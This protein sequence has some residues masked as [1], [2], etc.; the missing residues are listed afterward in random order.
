MMGNAVL[1]VSGLAGITLY[2]PEELILTA[3][4]GTPLREINETIAR[5]GQ[6]LAF[7]PPDFG[8]LWNLPMDRGTI[9]GCLAV[10]WGGSRRPH[11]GS[12][13]DHFLG[14]EAVN[15]LGKQYAAGGRVVKN[16]TGFDLPKLLAGSFGT[17][18][19]LTEVTIK[20]LP[21]PQSTL[22]LA[23][24]DL[25]DRTAVGLLSDMLATPAQISGA[26]HLPHAVVKLSRVDEIASSGTALTLVRLE[27]IDVSVAARAQALQE[28]VRKRQ[29]SAWRLDTVAS[30]A[31]WREITNAH[32]FSADR[33]Q[34][35]WRLSVPPSSGPALMQAIA[36][37][38]AS[39]GFFDWAGGLLWISV[40]PSPDAYAGTIRAALRSVAGLDGHATLVRAPDAV[41]E[42]VSPFE[43]LT[44][45]LMTLTRRVKDQF[46]PMHVLNRARKYP[47]F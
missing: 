42:S 2:E 21:S 15:G 34:A 12:A 39:T 38:E 30:L 25:D 1:D 13:R 6:Q 10:G 14:L 33:Q 8:A 45:E 18:G 24:P 5:A 46:D 4:A 22:T 16:V 3:R 36:P 9:G 31:L 35:V 28:L 23:V 27:G 29:L 43:P 7:E 41:R 44:A 40:P 19:V 37:I 26:A 32:F 47:E 17:L 20:V 11:A